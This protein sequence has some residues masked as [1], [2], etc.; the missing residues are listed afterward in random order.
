MKNEE[1]KVARLSLKS[2]QNFVQLYQQNPFDF[3]SV[4]YLIIK[5]VPI[6]ENRY[7][8]GSLTAGSRRA[9]TD[10]SFTRMPLTISYSRA[11]EVTCKYLTT[12]NF[13]ASF[14]TSASFVDNLSAC[15][16]RS[17]VTLSMTIMSPTF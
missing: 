17:I 1:P 10:L 16:T 4:R 3:F 5:S 8:S 9:T 2:T 14:S 7:Y 15:F 11:F 6:N 12:R 13:F